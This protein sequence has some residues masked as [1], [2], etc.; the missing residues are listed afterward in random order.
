MTGKVGGNSCLVAPVI[1]PSGAKKINKVY[2][3]A[4]DGNAS[5]SESF[6]FYRI[7]PATGVVTS[8]GYVDTGDSA[9]IT[10]YEIPIS[11]ATL[12]NSYAYQLTTCVQDDIKVYGAKVTYKPAM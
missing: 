12:S 2:V 9:G 3:Y 6:T 7:D 5:A 4:Q 1:F 8:L 10:Q 11:D